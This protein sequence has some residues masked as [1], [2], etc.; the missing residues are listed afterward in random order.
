M[1]LE[2][3]EWDKDLPIK[4]YPELAEWAKEAGIQEKPDWVD[5][6]NKFEDWMKTK[7]ERLKKESQN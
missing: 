3:T 2:L 4:E 6:I 5:N 7:S 1:P